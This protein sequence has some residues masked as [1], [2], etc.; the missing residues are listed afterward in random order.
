MSDLLTD[1]PVSTPCPSCGARALTASQKLRAK[2]TGTYSIAGA[3]PKVAATVVWELTCTAD[4]YGFIGDG[5]L[6]HSDD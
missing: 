3:W 5:V 1:L 6:K 2:P 4:D